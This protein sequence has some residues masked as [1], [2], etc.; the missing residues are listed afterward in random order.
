MTRPYCTAGVA[1]VVIV[2]SLFVVSVPCTVALPVA[3]RDVVPTLVAVIVAAVA[4][5]VIV[6]EAL[7]AKMVVM[8]LLLILSDGALRATG[9]ESSPSKP[10]AASARKIPVHPVAVQ[11]IEPPEQRVGYVLS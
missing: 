9:G 11:L 6:G 3:D 4:T 8:S 10:Y 5:P 1:P 7:G 2:T